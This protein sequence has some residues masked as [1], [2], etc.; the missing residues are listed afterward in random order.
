MDQPTKAPAWDRAWGVPV[1]AGRLGQLVL[2]LTF[3]GDLAQR[4]WQCDERLLGTR[5]TV[6]GVEV[7]TVEGRYGRPF[8]EISVVVKFDP[9]I[10]REQLA[11]KAIRLPLFEVVE[12]EALTVTFGGSS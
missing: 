8:E 9:G 6:D 7:G 11:E 1:V 4:V 5:V 12:R 2:D 3:R 10:T